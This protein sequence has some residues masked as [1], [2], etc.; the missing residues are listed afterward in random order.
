MLPS[1]LSPPGPGQCVSRL[2]QPRVAVALQRVDL[3]VPADSRLRRLRKIVGLWFVHVAILRVD[4]NDAIRR[5]AAVAFGKRI[6][7][8]NQRVARVPDD[9]Q[10]RMIE[11]REQARGLGAGRD[12]AGVLVFESDGHVVRRRLIGQAAKRADNRGRS[13]PRAAPSANTRRRG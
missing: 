3:A 4:V 12:V 13:T 10:I 5:H 7:A 11:R 1:C 6:L 9:L 8:G 2:I